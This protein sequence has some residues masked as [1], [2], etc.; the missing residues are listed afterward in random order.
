MRKLRALPYVK[1]LKKDSK[2]ALYWKAH[3]TTPGRKQTLCRRGS[4]VFANENSIDLIG[5]Y[6]AEMD[7][8]NYHKTSLC[9]LG[10]PTFNTYTHTNAHTQHTNTHAHKCTNAFLIVLLI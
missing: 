9:D 3:L 10:F 1:F 8:L 6:V 5:N 2:M 4:N 7:L